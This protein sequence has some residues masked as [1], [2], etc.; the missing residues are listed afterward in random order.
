MENFYKYL[1]IDEL[2]TSLVTFAPRV[3][4]ALVIML[5]F[6]LVYRIS[7]RP[8]RLALAHTGLHEKLIDLLVG[9]IY[10][11]AMIAFG[12]VMSLSQLGVDVGAAVA[13]LGVAGI[14]VGLAAQDTLSNTIAGFTIFWDKPFVVN[15]YKSSTCPI[16]PS[17]A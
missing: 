8:L 13:G 14:A 9:S 7:S 11:Y 6:W 2:V 10:R 16:S 1:N 15:D 5:V 4:V 3:I 12:L 17:R